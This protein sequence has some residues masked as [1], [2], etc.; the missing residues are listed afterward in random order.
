MLFF[1][2]RPLQRQPREPCHSAL[3]R[4][5]GGEKVRAPP[6]RAP[7]TLLPAPER[8]LARRRPLGSQDPALAHKS[9][10]RRPSSRTR[11]P[12]AKKCERCDPVATAAAPAAV[13]IAATTRCR[14]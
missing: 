2:L 8:T 11:P 3:S 1:L 12:L 14:E 13:V 6:P 5:V 7:L 9:R 10:T 4:S